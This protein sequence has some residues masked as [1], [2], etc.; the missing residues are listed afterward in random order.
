MKRRDLFKA[1]AVTGAAL[2]FPAQRLIAAAVGSEA[3]VAPFSVPMPIPP[4]LQPVR[5]TTTTDYYAI[6]QREADV[7]IIPGTTTRV[8]TFN[9]SFP[10][11]TINSLRGRQVVVTQTNGFSDPVSTHLHGGHVTPENDGYVLDLI[12]P[13]QSKQYTY[14]N[15]QAGA[16]LWYHDHAHHT[17]SEHVYRGQSGF[18][19]IYDPKEFKLALPW[20]VNDV[21]IMLRA[22]HLDDNAQL[23][24]TPNDFRGRNTILVNGKPQPYFKVGARKYRFRFLNSANDTAFKLSLVDGSAIVHVASDGGLLPA[25]VTTTNVDIFPGERVDAV[26]DFSRYPVGSSVVLQNEYGDSDQ[27]RLVMRFDIDHVE[28]DASRI[29]TAAELPD[30]PPVPA[31][32]VNRTVTLGIDPQTFMFLLNGKP[33]DPNRVDFQ[34]KQNVPEVWSITNLD[35]QFG[36]PHNLHLHLMQFQVLD[37]NGVPPGPTE[38]GWKDTVKV[39]PGETVRIAVTFKDYTGRYLFHCHLLDHSVGSMM[40]QLEI[41]R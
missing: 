41:T 10:G 29:P 36:I 38:Q 40:A 35:T 16:T 33:F 39:W 11:P 30:M 2:L 18:Y 24:Y 4:V 3:T 8:R 17:E 5:R 13:G 1:G 12:Q 31:P 14:P 15:T 20:G 26:I 7:E 25:P 28:D 6:T 37:R 27:T 9:G 23:V 19:L 22:V 21:P 34:V 32:V